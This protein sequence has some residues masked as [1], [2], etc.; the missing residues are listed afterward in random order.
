M[1]NDGERKNDLQRRKEIWEQKPF[2]TDKYID[3]DW[4]K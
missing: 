1:E 3:H 2:T 4:I